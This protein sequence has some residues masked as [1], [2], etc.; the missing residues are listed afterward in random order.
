MAARHIGQMT[1]FKDVISLD[2]GGT[3]TDV[4][5]ISDSK[6]T[7]TTEGKLGDWPMHLPMVDIATIGA[8]GGSIA[9][10]T[11]SG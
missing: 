9:W 1:G 2:M 3:S 4:S 10:L 6:V 11:Q 8:G 7:S 5:L